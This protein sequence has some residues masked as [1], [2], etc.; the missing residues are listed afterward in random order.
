MHPDG[1]FDREVRTKSAPDS[2]TLGP[3][4]ALWYAA[5][6]QGRI[7]RYDPDR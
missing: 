3:D 5:S 2:S 6:D 4:G 7:G 1:T